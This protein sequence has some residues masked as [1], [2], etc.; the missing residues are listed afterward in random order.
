[1][2]RILLFA[3]ALILSYFTAPYLGKVY[4]YFVPQLGSSFLGIGKEVAVYVVGFPF[5]YV[6]FTTFIFQIFGG[7]NKK[8]WTIWLLVPAFLLFIL[9]DIQHI[10]LPILLALIAFSLAKLTNLIILRFK[11]PS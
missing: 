2:S 7:V 8:K 10:Y 6:F 4:D 3:V 11:H 5:S 9:G 1:M